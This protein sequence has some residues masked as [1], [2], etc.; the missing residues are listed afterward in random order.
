MLYKKYD[1]MGLERYYLSR[2]LEDGG[3]LWSPMFPWNGCG[4]YQAATLGVPT[5]S[6]FPYVFLSLINPFVSIGMAFLNIAVFRVGKS[7]PI[8]GKVKEAPVET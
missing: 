4:A 6:Y 1:E 5:F 2:T 8:K 3:T 7:D